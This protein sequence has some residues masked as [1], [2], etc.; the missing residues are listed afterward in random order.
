MLEAVLMGGGIE[1]KCLPE[2]GQVPAALQDA[3]VLPGALISKR[4]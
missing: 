2:A 4:I 3:Q 1:G